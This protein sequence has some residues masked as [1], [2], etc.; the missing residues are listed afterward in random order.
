M[1]KKILFNQH[2]IEF[3]KYICVSIIAV[4]VDFS[5]YSLFLTYSIFPINYAGT[6]SYLI[7]LFIAYFLLKLYVFKKSW[8]KKRYKIEV[9]LFFISGIIGATI[10]FLTISVY[11]NIYQK[12]SYIAKFFASILSFIT[13]YLFRK[14][15]V[16]K[17]DI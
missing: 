11:Q 4:I 15:Y 3:I 16:F 12:G 14:F 9:F 5:I 2:T 17:K 1:I 6:T 10:T 7:G 13:V 8:L